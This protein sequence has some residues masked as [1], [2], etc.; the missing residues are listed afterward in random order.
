[1]RNAERAPKTCIDDVL[2]LGAINSIPLSWPSEHISTKFSMHL[3][4]NI[5]QQH[6]AGISKDDI[7][8]PERHTINDNTKILNEMYHPRERHPILSHQERD[9]SSVSPAKAPL[10]HEITS[11]IVNLTFTAA[12]MKGAF[13]GV[14]F[15][16][17]YRIVSSPGMIDA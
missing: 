8:I 9:K 2:S 15:T 17:K 1:M 4:Q 16:F 5:V 14:A 6:C 12:V 3:F 10:A 11:P 7:I 13:T